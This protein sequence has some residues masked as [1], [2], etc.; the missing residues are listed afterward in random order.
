MGKHFATVAGLYFELSENIPNDEI[1]YHY[2]LGDAD[3]EHGD[4]N[5]NITIN[6]S[7]HNKFEYYIPME[8]GLFLSIFNFLGAI[9]NV[10]VFWT[11]ERWY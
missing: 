9:E 10:V 6:I 11:I 3:T 8:T 7:S 2:F 1:P 4:L 5:Q